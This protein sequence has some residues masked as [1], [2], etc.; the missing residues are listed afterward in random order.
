[1]VFCNS[2]F[3]QQFHLPISPKHVGLQDDYSKKKKKNSL[4]LKMCSQ[5]VVGDS[6]FSR[7][8]QSVCLI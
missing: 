5:H 2:C 1:M 8:A 3:S 7:W 4:S 6:P